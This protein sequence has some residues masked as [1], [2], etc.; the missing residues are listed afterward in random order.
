MAFASVAGIS[1]LGFRKTDSNNPNNPPTYSPTYFDINEKYLEKGNF[2]TIDKKSWFGKNRLGR[3]I[4][5]DDENNQA[6]IEF[7]VKDTYDIYPLEKIDLEKIDPQPFETAFTGNDIQKIENA[8]T[9]Y[10]STFQKR[11]F[12]QKVGFS[13]T[14][15]MKFKPLAVGNTVEF[16]K[17]D[18]NWIGKVVDF[19]PRPNKFIGYGAAETVYDVVVN[20][21]LPAYFINNTQMYPAL[22]LWEKNAKGFFDKKGGK[23]SRYKTQKN[24]HYKRT[25]KQ[26]KKRTKGTKRIKRI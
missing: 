14:N 12:F 18:L 4:N 5:I 2:V 15:P 19:K 26:R 3:V 25:Q 1:S 8:A 9:N 17:L 23:Y 7:Y 20:F 24:K 16:L 21:V 10:N 6:T 13:S 11:S 22:I